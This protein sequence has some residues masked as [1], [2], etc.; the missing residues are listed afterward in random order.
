MADEAY[1]CDNVKVIVRNREKLSKL[2]DDSFE[3]QLEVLAGFGTD[4]Y[5][6]YDLDPNE[7]IT[8]DFPTE[9]FIESTRNMDAESNEFVDCFCE[10]MDALMMTEL[11]KRH[12]DIDKLHYGIENENGIEYEYSH[13][14]AEQYNQLLESKRLLWYK[15]T[16]VVPIKQIHRDVF[17]V[18]NNRLHEFF[19]EGVF[20]CYAGD[21]RKIVHIEPLTEEQVSEQLALIRKT[22][23]DN[24]DNRFRA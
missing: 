7:I 10:T 2:R 6:L 4:L 13:I 21:T 20:R 9:Q 16:C 1:T 17:F 24:E 8:F 22:I 19:D 15:I 14:T 3:G 18:P 12:I 5:K 11:K 23:K